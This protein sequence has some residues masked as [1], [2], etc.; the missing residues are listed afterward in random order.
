MKNVVD[1]I[2]DPSRCT[3]TRNFEFQ[4]QTEHHD[5]LLLLLAIFLIILVI[6][7]DI[8]NA[9]DNVDLPIFTLEHSITFK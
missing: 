6:T 9:G 3:L 4:I 1:E 7:G 5:Q 2:S 8:L